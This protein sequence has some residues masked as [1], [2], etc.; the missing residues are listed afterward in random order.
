MAI[1]L[2]GWWSAGCSLVGRLAS[3][4][5]TT[6][7]PTRF[8]PTTM[9]CGGKESSGWATVISWQ[10][11]RPHLFPPCWWPN[12]A[13]LEK[14]DYLIWET[15]VSGFDSFRIGSRNNLNMKI[16]KYK[17]VLSMEKGRRNIKEPT[18]VLM[19]KFDILKKSEC[20]ISQTWTSD[21]Y[22]YEMVNISKW[23]Q[24]L[25]ISQVR[26]YRHVFQ[27]M[28]VFLEQFGWIS[29]KKKRSSSNNK[30]MNSN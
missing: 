13:R 22:S 1:A 10:A 2:C 30:N 21:F 9:S 19:T 7:L 23:R 6:P 4:A 14:L 20:P 26:P 24:N 5:S 11:W 8:L 25:Y 15:G 16:W 17:Y 28:N 18:H 27:V 3:T 12:L 29:L